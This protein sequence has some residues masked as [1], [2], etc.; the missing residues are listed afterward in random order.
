[1][2][3]RRVADPDAVESS[4]GAVEGLSLLP[5]ETVLT[6][7]KRTE[8]VRAETPAGVSFGAYAIHAGRTVLTGDDPIDRFATL[9]DGS[10]DGV[11]AARVLGTYLHGSFESV[12]VCTEVFGVA[13]SR[14]LKTE[15]YD[16]LADWFERYARNLQQLDLPLMKGT[17]A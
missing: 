3:G 12:G 14:A 2:L 15:S 9:S 17:T 6:K 13:P 8:A 5:V 11:R 10:T 4:L 7:H 16:R 1:M